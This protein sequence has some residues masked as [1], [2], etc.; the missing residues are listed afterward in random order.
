MIYHYPRYQNV[1]KDTVFL[2]TET[3]DSEKYEEYDIPYLNEGCLTIL[4]IKHPQIKEL[5][6]RGVIEKFEKPGFFNN[7]SAYSIPLSITQKENEKQKNLS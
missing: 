2:M 6:S 3:V 4:N 1:Y 5:I 7:K